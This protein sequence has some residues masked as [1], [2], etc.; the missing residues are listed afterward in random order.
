V[1]IAELIE[2]NFP[3]LVNKTQKTPS[4]L[5][6]EFND[7]KLLSDTLFSDLRSFTRL[8]EIYCINFI[9]NLDKIPKTYKLKT[10]FY[11]RIA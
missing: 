11:H 1:L 5:N 2:R 9:D 10:N 6:Y 8:F 4:H 3:D 7:V